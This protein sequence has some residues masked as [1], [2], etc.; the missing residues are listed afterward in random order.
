MA[1]NF[2][3]SLGHE[4]GVQLNPTI[5]N[6]EGFAVDAVEDQT[7]A[8]VARLPRGPIGRAFEVHK[9]N[10]LRTTGRPEP[11]RIN[12]LNDAHTQLVESL[13]K[14]AKRA[15]VSRL[16]GDD[17]SNKW[18]I[19]KEPETKN[20]VYELVAELA[21]EVPNSK[22]I[23]ALKHHGCFNDGI[24]L[25]ISA[26][27]VTD[28][29]G[30]AIDAQVM[31]LKVMDRTKTV[32]NEFSGSI[33]LN[34]V[35]DD[36]YPNNLQAQIANYFSDD[37]ELVLS[38]D[39]FIPKNC[40]AY[41]KDENGIARV[42]VT[43]VLHPFS[44]G[45]VGN[46]TAQ[47]YQAAVKQ[48]KDTDSNF[49]YISSLGSKSTA[50]C[51]ALAQL[52][53][54]KNIQAM[55]DIPNHLTPKQAISWVNQLGLSSHL[56]SLLWHPVECNDPSGVS[57]RVKIGTS[58]L[59]CALSC[60][61]NATKNHLGFSAKQYAVAGIRFPIQRQGMKQL[62]K[63]DDEELSD[64]A[65]AG[66]TP[67]IFQTFL[68]SSKYV[69][70]DAITK[71]GKETSFLNLISSVEIITTLERDA[72]RIAR[73]FLLFMPMKEA[74][75]TS[76]RAISEHFDAAKDS[77]WLINSSELGGKPYELQIIP[78]PQRPNDVMMLSWRAH[79]EGCV[80]QVHITSTITR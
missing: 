72:S 77:G 56:L 30:K 25:S 69:F 78:N 13:N 80:R 2:T 61:R 6:S 31:T 70:A 44:E 33:D 14:G 64:L 26:P 36:G 71:A 22:F 60:Q 19:V 74:I 21:E 79:P 54:D 63:P 47:Q 27:M 55:I 10:V 11:I 45:S 15:V 49:V 7:F 48:L 28:N 40:A 4:P 35:N 29:G 41:G 32:L 5:D 37:Y 57:G 20:G 39:A 58:A 16:V 76:Y 3:R 52:A 51:A 53:F 73:E 46:F 24:R 65:Q 38:Q 75:E 50:L 68:N 67:V 43:E 9:G 23:F 62:Y 8:A 59:R 18:I 34:S 1:S 12:A 42:Q 17:A 66:I